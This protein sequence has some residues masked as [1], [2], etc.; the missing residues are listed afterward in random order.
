MFAKKVALAAAVAGSL[1]VAG[2]AQSAPLDLNVESVVGTWTAVEGGANVIGVGTSS[3]SWGIPFPDADNGDQSGYDFNGFAPPSF[4]EVAPSTFEVGEFAHRNFPISDGATGASLSV[5]IMGTL[6]DGTPWSLNPNYTFT[7][8]ETP[9]D[10]EPCPGGDGIPCG[11]IVSFTLDTPGSET[12]RV[13]GFLYT[14]SL[15]GF[16]VGGETVDKFL[17]A[18]SAVN[19]APL[20]ASFEVAPIPVPAA[21]PMFLGALGVFAVINRRRAANAA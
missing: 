16:S 10:A 9:N 12:F 20:V 17:T 8:F 2:A 18:E 6:S 1:A 7:H 14:I 21:L 3:V 11:D 19:T 5:M 15:L 13:D 4:T